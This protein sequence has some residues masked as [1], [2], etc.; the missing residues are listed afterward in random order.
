MS[1]KKELLDELTEIQ[2][3]ELAEDK[4]IK[5]SLSKLEKIYYKNWDERDKLVDLMA[6]RDDL[7]IKEIEEYI[8]IKKNI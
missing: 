6:S 5:I 3:K 2:L 8:K 4:G 7:K 1:I